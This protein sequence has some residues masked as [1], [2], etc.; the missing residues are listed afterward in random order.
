MSESS[1]VDS[2]L[3]N[4]IGG[5][6]YFSHACLKDK[7][8][9]PVDNNPTAEA[10]ALRRHKKNMCLAPHYGYW[11]FK[12]MQGFCDSQFKKKRHV[13]VEHL[14][15]EERRKQGQMEVSLYSQALKHLQQYWSCEL[16]QLEQA[17]QAGLM[18]HFV[19]VGG[20]YIY[21][22]N[23]GLEVLILQA[24][25]CHAKAE[26]ELYTVAIQN[27]HEFDFSDNTSASSSPIFWVISFAGTVISGGHHEDHS[28]AQR[29]H[30]S[31]MDIPENDKTEVVVLKTEEEFDR[32]IGRV[33][34]HHNDYTIVHFV[35][36]LQEARMK[37]QTGEVFNSSSFR[38]GCRSIW[39]KRLQ[40]HENQVLASMG[41]L[42]PHLGHD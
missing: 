1:L 22:R 13:M 3:C 15:M 6:Y 12:T 14:L 7:V 34:T 16:L 20:N 36:S 26:I 28:T 38:R 21:Q 25:M 41:M 35:N 30:P 19:T 40:L 23:I 39:Q 18:A 9:P 8:E 5:E 10:S 37:D 2:A 42:T 33:H 17:Y 27:A 24:K 29:S 4:D 11:G 32:S 31:R